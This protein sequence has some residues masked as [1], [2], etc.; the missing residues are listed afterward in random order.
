[1]LEKKRWLIAVTFSFIAASVL[2]IVLM[3]VIS[4][5]DFFEGVLM[6][7]FVL[8]STTE[9]ALRICGSG[10]FLCLFPLVRGLVPLSGAGSCSVR[11]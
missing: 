6:K 9:Q 5:I 2:L 7:W 1:M 11:G 8:G 3:T 10:V 4:T